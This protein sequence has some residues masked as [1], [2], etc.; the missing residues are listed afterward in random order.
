MYA[1]AS[2]DESRPEFLHALMRARPLATLVTLASTGLEA[3]HLPLLFVT[4]VAG[5]PFGLLQGHVAR[6]NLVWQDL[7]AGVEALAIFHGPSS[8]ITPSWY[9]TKSTDGR[10][11]PT[12]NYVVVHAYGRIR[13]VDDPAWLRAHLAALTRQQESAQPTPWH[14]DDA[15][16]AHLENLLRGIVGLEFTI[17]RLQGKWKTS[18]NQSAPNR[19]GVIS[20]LRA[21]AHP[22]AQEMADWVEQTG[23]RDLPAAG[24]LPARPSPAKPAGTGGAEFTPPT[25]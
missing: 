22:E 12:W 13:P 1:P 9:P 10:V 6:A 3:N 20:G 25:K 4:D 7:A 24:G 16:A 14:V 2:F 5:A 11:V 18:Q 8:Y 15:P 17:T 19:A 21:L 23:A